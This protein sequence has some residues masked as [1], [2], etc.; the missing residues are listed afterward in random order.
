M[1]EEMKTPEEMTAPQNQES[2]EDYTQEL[3]ASFKKIE[4]G[5]IITGTVISISDTEVTLDLRYYAEG[6]IKN[7]DFSR[8]PGYSVKEHVSVGD[9]VSATVVKTDDGRGNI[10][11][12][13]VEA[14]DTL[15]WQ[16]LQELKDSKTILDVTVKGVVNA[17]VIAYVED[18]RGFIPASK[19]SL[20]YVENLEDYL[21][22][23]IQVRV[24]D[25]DKEK[26]RLILSA[27]E[28]L[29]E[30]AE[31]ERK[32]RISNVAVG[33]VTE[34]VVES[35]QPY[36]AFVNLGN[37][38]SGLVHI[39]QISEKRIKTPSEC[40]SVGDQ[41][42]VKVIAIKDGKLSLSMKALNDVAA[43][44]IEEETFELPKSEE[45]TTNLG[46]LFKNLKL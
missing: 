36:G 2:M 16:K 13:R 17:G 43:K 31:E 26:N 39:S 46:S 4:E 24:F 8:M 6:I 3:E 44:E 20:S 9:E 22:K 40:L 10:L 14:N 29:R 19:L 27:R 11:L 32:A 23:P 34:G 18:V 38:L 15:A 5:D 41:V 30:K 25:L 12:S 45:V 21:N 33:L 35:I 42:K 1:S 37:G 7:E 28:I